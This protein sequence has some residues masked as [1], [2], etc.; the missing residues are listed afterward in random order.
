M[1]PGWS[2]SGACQHPHHCLPLR[3]RA[4]LP[5]QWGITSLRPPPAAVGLTILRCVLQAAADFS[6]LQRT[7]VA[8]LEDRLSARGS[9]ASVPL[10]GGTD[11]SASASAPASAQQRPPLQEPLPDKAPRQPRQPQQQQ[12]LP[13]L[14]PSPS[15]AC[16]TLSEWADTP[17][18]DDAPSLAGREQEVG[19]LMAVLNRL[20]FL[21]LVVGAC[22]LSGGRW[23]AGGKSGSPGKAPT[24]G[25]SR[26]RTTPAIRR[27]PKH[28]GGAV[29]AAMVRGV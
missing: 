18:D 25:G 23:R 26:T 24:G 7:I 22:S 14:S 20:I 28:I 5:A 4:A 17:D 9:T 11:G 29:A 1:R 3:P 8:L 6:T 13:G 12:Q 2:S 21:G 10:R 16:R 15:P 19:P 27:R